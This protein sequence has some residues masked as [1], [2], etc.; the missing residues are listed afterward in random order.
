MITLTRSL[1]RHLRAV[2]RQLNVHSQTEL[3]ELFRGISPS[4]MIPTLRQTE[5][6]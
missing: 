6:V 2:F 5:H 4:A 1:A 3:L